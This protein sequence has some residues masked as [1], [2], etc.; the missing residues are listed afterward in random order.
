MKTKISFII[1]SLFVPTFIFAQTTFTIEGPEK[2]YN[3]IRII[4]ETSQTNFA[5][6]VSRLDKYNSTKNVYGVFYLKEKN[7]GDMVSDRNRIKRGDQI[8]IEMPYDFPT[9]VYFSIEYKDYPLWDAIV[10]HIYDTRFEGD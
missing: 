10:I 2:S 5:V 1:L 3:Q 4:N 6:R 7:D 9:K 8:V